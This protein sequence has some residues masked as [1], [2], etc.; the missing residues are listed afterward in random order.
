MKFDQHLK[1]KNSYKQLKRQF[2]KSIFFLILALFYNLIWINQ[3]TILLS[4][5][6]LI[7]RQ[8]FMMPIK[9]PGSLSSTFCNVVK[10]GLATTTKLST[11]PRQGQVRSAW[12]GKRPDSFPWQP[13]LWL[14]I[15]WALHLSPLISD[16]NFDSISVKSSMKCK[17]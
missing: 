5:W 15:G 13:S 2:Q 8:T 12:S 16:L 14:V 11:L 9:N 1:Q 3:T 17:M 4:Q 7:T 10:V 6:N